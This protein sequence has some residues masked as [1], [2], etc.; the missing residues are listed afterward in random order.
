MIPGS[1]H[2][3]RIPA[4]NSVEVP[5]RERCL[6]NAGWLSVAMFKADSMWIERNHEGVLVGDGSIRHPLRV[7]AL[8]FRNAIQIAKDNFFFGYVLNRPIELHFGYLVG[9]TI[10][11]WRR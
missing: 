2:I 3:R 11:T 9:M 5:Y 1:N 4:E 7:L 8:L 6:E 10:L